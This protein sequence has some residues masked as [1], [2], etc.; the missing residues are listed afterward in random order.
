MDKFDNVLSRISKTTSAGASLHSAATSVATI[1]RTFS[2]RASEIRRRTD[3]SAEGHRLG[4]QGQAKGDFIR[5]M[6]E[7]AKPIHQA[8]RTIESQRSALHEIRVPDRKDVVAALERQEL[9]A[10]VRS[11]DVGARMTFLME[12]ISNDGLAEAV[13]TANPILSGL[14][15][16]SAAEY[17]DRYVLT[18]RAANLDA[19]EDASADLE[20]AEAIVQLARQDIRD[21]SKFDWAEFEI[22]AAPI[23]IAVNH[24]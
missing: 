20:A 17:R 3:L 1:A 22:I 18:S 24:G 2:E 9:R 8:R 16:R 6:L 7:A 21:E 14:N 11:M 12:N 23:E 5:R 19:F 4:I 13:L 10:L 15:D